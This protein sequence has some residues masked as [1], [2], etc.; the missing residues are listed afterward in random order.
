MRFF[1]AN[2]SASRRERPLDKAT[3]QRRKESSRPKVHAKEEHQSSQWLRRTLT[4]SIEWLFVNNI[5]ISE[6][7]ASIDALA[8][9]TFDVQV[10]KYDGWMATTP[11][12]QCQ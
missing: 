10:H 12:Q 5:A 11:F 4:C 8:T 7:K 9:I 1:F 6:N 2:R 3:S